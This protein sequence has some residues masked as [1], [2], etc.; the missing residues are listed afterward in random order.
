MS[1]GRGKVFPVRP[2]IGLRGFL[3]RRNY[4]VP[5]DGPE[6]LPPFR[7]NCGPGAVQDQAPSGDRHHGWPRHAM[8][9]GSGSA[10]PSRASSRK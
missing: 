3:G 7:V 2:L 9:F 6:H 10:C 8:T 1:I 5:P 4:L